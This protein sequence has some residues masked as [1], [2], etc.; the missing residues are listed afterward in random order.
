MRVLPQF[1]GSGTRTLIGSWT[2]LVPTPRARTA[3]TTALYLMFIASQFGHAR[4]DHEHRHADLDSRRVRFQR[5]TPKA[6][7]DYYNHARTHLEKD[8]GPSVLG[9]PSRVVTIGRGPAH[10]EAPH[11]QEGLSPLGAP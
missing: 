1:R 2:K 6:Y 8:S 7:A 11:P 9:G 3:T 5:E 4:F 10:L